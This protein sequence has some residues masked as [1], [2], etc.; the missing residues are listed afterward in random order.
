MFGRQTSRGGAMSQ[1]GC[2][3]LCGLWHGH[4]CLLVARRRWH[5]AFPFN[6]ASIV[7][8]ACYPV[9]L[10]GMLFLRAPVLL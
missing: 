8:C 6:A 1:V 3:V 9:C 5:P 4:L 7:S 2:A 10:T